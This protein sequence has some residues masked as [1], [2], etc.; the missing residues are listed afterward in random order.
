M[1]LD[2]EKYAELSGEDYKKVLIDECNHRRARMK[3][4]SARAKRSKVRLRKRIGN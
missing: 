4:K 2:N 3:V 1:I